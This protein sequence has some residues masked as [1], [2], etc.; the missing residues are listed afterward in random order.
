MVALA[1][2]LRVTLAPDIGGSTG[3]LP[4]LGALLVVGLW[5]HARA[6]P[7][8]TWLLA[9]A[10]L[11]AVSLTF[12]ALDGPLCAAWPIGTHFLWHML[13]GAVLGLLLVALVRHGRPARR[14]AG[15]ARIA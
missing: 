9:A 10:G 7:A 3:Y 4:P 1:V 5:L 15:P 6:H 2:L 13:N 12:R 11:F 8:G 14:L